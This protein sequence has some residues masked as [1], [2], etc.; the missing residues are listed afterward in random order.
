MTTFYF[1]KTNPNL[2]IAGDFNICH[3]A[4]DIH[5]PIR[6]KNVSGFLP[7]ERNWLSKF[8]ELGF[9]DSFRFLIKTLTNTAGGHIGLMLEL[10]IRVGELIILWFH[11]LLKI[12]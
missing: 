1:K 5:D 10:I 9:I 4:I 11:N 2:I 8:I 12:K 6:N 3:K 7:V